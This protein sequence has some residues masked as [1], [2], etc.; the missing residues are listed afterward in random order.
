MR[1]IVRCFRDNKLQFESDPSNYSMALHVALKANDDEYKYS[2]ITILCDQEGEDHPDN[3]G[4][5][6]LYRI[7]K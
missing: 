1:Y 5:F 3:A 4:K 6:F 2:V 7:I